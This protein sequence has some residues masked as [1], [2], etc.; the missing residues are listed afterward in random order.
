MNKIE[1]D[2]SDMKMYIFVNTDLKM[3]K[4]KACAQVG[5]AVQYVI[6]ELFDI[7]IKSF[8]NPT[9][10][11]FRGFDRY[12]VWKEDFGSAK[13]TLKA[14]TEQLLELKEMPEARYVIDEGRTQIPKGSLTV[15]AFFPNYVSSMEFAKKF[16]LY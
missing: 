3:D 14:T 12:L 4:G 9:K 10:Y 5:H 6:E 7:H 8:E 16:S 1:I 11:L 15:V 13:V 2:Q